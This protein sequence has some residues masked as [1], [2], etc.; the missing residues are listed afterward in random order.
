VPAETPGL[1]AAGRE[2]TLGLRAASI[3][4]LYLQDCRVPASY[5]LGAEGQGYKIALEALDFGR[6]GIAA[7]ALGI[8]KRAVDLGVKFAGERVQFGVPIGQKQAIQMYLAD[9]ATDVAAAEWLVRHAAW[10]AEQGKPYGSEA[11][12]AKLFTSRMAASVTNKIVQ[13]HGGNGYMA[14]Y[15]IQ[16]YF[17]DARAMEILEGTT[18]IQQIIIA[19]ALLGRAGIKARP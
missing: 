8:A 3:T 18:Q 19:G 4:R 6:V 11:S 7:V 14:D 5:L 17:R 15:P 2:R 16:R 13:I 12:M 1:R 9:A 10:L